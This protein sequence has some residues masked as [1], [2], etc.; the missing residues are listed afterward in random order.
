MSQADFGTPPDAD[1]LQSN[2]L[3]CT[4][5][6]E[7]AHLLLLQQSEQ[8]NLAQ[9]V[10][11]RQEALVQSLQSQV[12]QL[13]QELKLKSEL[14]T[15]SLANGEDLRSRLKRQQHQTSQLK[16]ALER[17]LESPTNISAR[18][19]VTAL[20]SWSASKLENV[21]EPSIDYEAVKE[22]AKELVRPLMP[23]VLQN[24][25]Q[26]KSEVQAPDQPDESDELD[27]TFE[28]TSPELPERKIV[29]ELGFKI[30][31]ASTTVASVTDVT[32]LSSDLEQNPQT[33][34]ALD[35]VALTQD[36]RDEDNF[37]QDGYQPNFLL[38]QVVPPQFIQALQK[39]ITKTEPAP[40]VTSQSG[41]PKV[42]SLAAVKLPQFPPLRR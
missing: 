32:D 17:C 28:P 41:K 20:E 16:T 18:V 27:Q 24:I 40:L 31:L 26:V 23:D 22:V 1:S 34:K 2:L 42:T 21:I 35:S 14:L 9:Q 39:T 11:E 15:Q 37:I 7:Q 19:E 8:L 29:P 33:E 13:D 3:D 25:V 5:K 36:D 38:S 10:I 4:A 12:D 6:C 30:P